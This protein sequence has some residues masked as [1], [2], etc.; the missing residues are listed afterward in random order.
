VPAW[1]GHVESVH[2]SADSWW[3][4]SNK[5]IQKCNGRC[6]FKYSQLEIVEMTSYLKSTTSE[7]TK[8]FHSSTI[9][10]NFIIKMMTVWKQVLSRLQ[11]NT[12]RNQKTWNAMRLPR[13]NVNVWVTMIL[14]NLF[15]DCDLISWRKGMKAV[16]YL[17]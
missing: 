16:Q 11:R 17:H 7:N 5:T 2:L 10:L 9:V 12:R 3:R 4:V 1:F 13:P 15:L 14:G 6:N 8:C